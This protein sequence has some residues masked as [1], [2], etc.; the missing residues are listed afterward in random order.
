MHSSLAPPPPH[1]PPTLWHNLTNISRPPVALS[2]LMI[3]VLV[4]SA[5]LFSSLSMVPMWPNYGLHWLLVVAFALFEEESVAPLLQLNPL[6]WLPSC[7]T[8]RKRKR[9]RTN[10]LCCNCSSCRALAE[11]R[12]KKKKNQI[13]IIPLVF[14]RF[15]C[16]S[17]RL[18]RVEEQTGNGR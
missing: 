2:S 10:S 6:H 18:L 3:G 17:A 12:Q 4:L 13:D 8:R 14:L 11:E 7:T 1:N 5:L 15:S 9:R 16:P